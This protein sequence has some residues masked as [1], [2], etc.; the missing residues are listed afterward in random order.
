MNYPTHIVSVGG[1]IENE[2]GKILM[3]KSPIRGWE[4]PG[5]QV[6]YGESL[7]DSL[8]REIKEESGIDIEVEKLIMV[9]SNIGPQKEGNSPSPTIVNTCFSGKAVSGE[10]AISEE[11]LEVGWF[12]RD[13]ILDKIGEDFMRDRARYML[14]YDGRIAYMIFSRNPY[15]IH[16][17][18]YI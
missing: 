6:E 5:G 2:E 18:Q 9:T 8:I 16:G 17:V 7:T 12:N 1:L 14:N 11:S 13:E 15:V 10:L 4:F 3:V